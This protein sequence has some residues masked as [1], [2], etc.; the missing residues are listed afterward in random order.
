[1][2]QT[3]REAELLVALEGL[4]EH[5]TMIHTRW[6]EGNNAQEADRAIALALALIAET[7]REARE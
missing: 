4:F 2:N 3:K 7:K 1:M 5:C 6:G